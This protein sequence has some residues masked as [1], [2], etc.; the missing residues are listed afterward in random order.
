MDADDKEL[1][2]EA[3]GQVKK[4]WLKGPLQLSQLPPEARICF[5]FGVRQTDKLRAIDDL[6]R[7]GTNKC[8]MCKP[9]LSSQHGTILQL[10]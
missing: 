6:K 4:G 5:R 7:S 8:L 1:F 9:Q 3:M 2:T 10:L